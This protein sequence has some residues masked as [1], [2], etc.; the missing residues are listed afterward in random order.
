MMPIRPA[1]EDDY[2]FV[3]D[4]WRDSFSRYSELCKRDRD[5]YVRV[6]PHI[7]RKMLRDPEVVSLVAHNPADEDNIIGYAVARGGELL[8]VYV[9]SDFRKHRVA[10]DLLERCGQITSYAFRTGQGQTRLRPDILGWSYRPYQLEI[11]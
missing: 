8:Y 1:R 9:R 4:S 7:I 3:I 2:G 10:R 11:A 6:M 5:L